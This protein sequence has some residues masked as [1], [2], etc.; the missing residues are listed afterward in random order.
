RSRYVRQGHILM[1]SR[2]ETVACFSDDELLAVAYLW[3]HEDG[4]REFCLA[5]KQ[6]AKVHM[7]ELCRFAHLTFAQMLD[8]EANVMTFV[9]P[10]HRPGER[11][12]RLVGFKPDPDHPGKWKLER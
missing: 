5:I 9:R 1:R 4:S 8:A 3:P 2:G 10:G 6:D 7:L 12:A 11:M